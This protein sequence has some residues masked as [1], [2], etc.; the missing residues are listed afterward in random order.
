MMDSKN[1]KIIE[2]T[3]GDS[4]KW[5]P[6][7]HK[8]DNENPEIYQLFETVTHSLFKDGKITNIH[9]IVVFSVVIN[10]VILGKKSPEA[11]DKFKNGKYD[12]FFSAENHGYMPHTPLLVCLVSKWRKHNPKYKNHII[13]LGAEELIR[14][15]DLTLEEIQKNNKKLDELAN[16]TIQ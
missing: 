11:R 2:D 6:K 4:D 5:L 12:K 10:E 8:F 7:W 15:F 1:R 3:F 16:L 14:T 9:P 13:M